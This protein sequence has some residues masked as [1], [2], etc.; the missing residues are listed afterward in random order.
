MEPQEVDEIIRA[1]VR[2]ATHQ[3]SINADLR[4]MLTRH[5]DRL[6]SHEAIT[7]RLTAAIERLDTTQARIETLLARMIHQQDNGREA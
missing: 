4:A 3:E 5:D 6:T 2:I 7:E 1:L